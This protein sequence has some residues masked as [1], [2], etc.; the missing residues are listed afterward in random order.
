M[1]KHAK[2]V[3]TMAAALLTLGLMSGCGDGG[4][5]GTGGAGAGKLQ[6]D[7][8]TVA[9][10]N[11]GTGSMSEP[12]AAKPSGSNSTK[13]GGAVSGLKEPAKADT[14]SSTSS[15]TSATVK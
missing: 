11:A 1:N 6:M 9:T 10:P 14:P 13:D 8:P 3:S 4:S 15:S 2:W 7:A 5:G 12:P